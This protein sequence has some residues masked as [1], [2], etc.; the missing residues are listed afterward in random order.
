MSCVG[1]G[2]PLGLE[3]TLLPHLYLHTVLSMGVATINNS[4]KCC[5]VY[6][7]VCPLDASGLFKV[8]L[9]G[10][11]VEFVRKKVPF[12]FLFKLGADHTWTGSTH[13]LGGP[14]DLT[15]HL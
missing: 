4:Q 6:T 9:C 11:F 15:T 1:R 2:T 12:S 8:S 3:E 5:T 13:L 7:R 14:S 10:W